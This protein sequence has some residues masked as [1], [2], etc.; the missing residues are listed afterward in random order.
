VLDKLEFFIF[1]KINVK[2]IKKSKSRMLFELIAPNK[3]DTPA[4]CKLNIAK[5]TDPPE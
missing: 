2:D 5:S 1:I 3:D 4:R